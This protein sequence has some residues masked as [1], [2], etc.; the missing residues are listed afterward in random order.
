MNTTDLQTKIQDLTTALRV[1]LSE[2][3][4]A[5]L[6]APLRELLADA[7]TIL[8]RPYTYGEPGSDPNVEQLPDGRLRIT[9]I[10]PLKS[11]SE[12]IES[13]LMRPATV[14]DQLDAE[15]VKATAGDAQAGLEKLASVLVIE[16]TNRTPAKAEL[17][18][19]IEE[20]AT[21][22]LEALG[23]LGGRFRRTRRAFRTS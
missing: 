17:R 22:L 15:K 6:T 18:H 3:Q 19:L 11:G 13:F 9:L 21:C 8:G 23:F 10:Q 7:N 14:G 4:R 1:E 5:D 12:V 20:D 2:A 16:G